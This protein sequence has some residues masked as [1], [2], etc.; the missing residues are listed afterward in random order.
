MAEHLLQTDDKSLQLLAI[1]RLLTDV[2]ANP[3]D[4]LIGATIGVLHIL[5][6]DR[7]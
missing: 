6:P 1:I 4:F 5:T 7:M 3:A 2:P